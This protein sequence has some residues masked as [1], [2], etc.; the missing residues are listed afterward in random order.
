M[1]PCY[2]LVDFFMRTPHDSPN[3]SGGVDP[4]TF[5][6][7]FPGKKFKADTVVPFDRSEDVYDNKMSVASFLL[8]KHRLTS[9]AG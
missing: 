1:W 2:W 4:H 3:L 5:P 9:T 6:D 7:V 8:R